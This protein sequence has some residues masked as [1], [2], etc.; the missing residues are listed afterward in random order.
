MNKII[1]NVNGILVCTVPK[2]RAY[3]SMSQNFNTFSTPH[4]PLFLVFGVSNAKYLAFGTP[5][6]ALRKRNAV[7]KKLRCL[8]LF[9]SFMTCI[10]NL[11]HFALFIS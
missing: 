11:I 2:M 4:N 10:L 6:N 1:I 3:C 9:S 5:D 7:C 8:A